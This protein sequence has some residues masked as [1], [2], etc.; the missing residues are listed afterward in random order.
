[1]SIERRLTSLCGQEAGGSWL[2][3]IPSENADECDDC[4]LPFGRHDLSI[5]H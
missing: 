4:H 3:H 1:M 2:T 5:E